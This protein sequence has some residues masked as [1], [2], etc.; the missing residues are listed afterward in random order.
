MKNHQSHLPRVMMPFIAV[1]Q[2]RGIFVE[3]SRNT[4]C[5]L[6]LAGVKV[7]KDVNKC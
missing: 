1:P 3:H 5:S 7:A 4:N 6:K 2:S